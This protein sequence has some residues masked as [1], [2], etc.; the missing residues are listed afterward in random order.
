MSISEEDRSFCKAMVALA[1]WRT[2]NPKLEPADEPD[3]VN[4]QRQLVML[5]LS[6]L[7]EGDLDPWTG[8]KIQVLVRKSTRYIV[9]L[10]DKFDV[11]W[12]WTQRLP[13]EEGLSLIQANVTRLTSA[14][15]FL[16]APQAELGASWPGRIK[17]FFAGEPALEPSGGPPAVVTPPGHLKPSH[18]SALQVRRLIAE[19]MAM[20]LNNASTAD[21]EKIQLKADEQILIEK[22]RQCRGVFFWHFFI[23]V[24]VAA[25]ASILVTQGFSL[26]GIQAAGSGAA[27]LSQVILAGAVGAFLSAL[28][29]TRQ[30]AL[31]PESGRA[32]LAAD[33]YARASIGAGV[34]M[35]VFYAFESNVILKGAL[36]TGAGIHEAAVY[37]LSIASGASER[38]MPA[39]VGRA[40]SLIGAKASPKADS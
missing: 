32:G 34:A 9:Y 36:S 30:L 33:A 18:A 17:S 31:E 5:R 10:D 11:Q 40:E 28:T 23:A 3:D 25:M 38:V 8:R 4:Q 26:W 12:W 37:F 6:Q 20:V 1:N 24:I 27:L 29:R 13:K 14:S 16:L 21:C 15:A 39:L 22:D 7:R 19:S 35:L 2:R